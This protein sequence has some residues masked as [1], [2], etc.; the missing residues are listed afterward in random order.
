MRRFNG[1]KVSTFVLAGALG[2][3]G[4][5]GTAHAVP[6]PQMRDAL[7]RLGEARAHLQAA[8]KHHGGHRERALELTLAA[9]DEVNAGI[10]WAN[11]H[12]D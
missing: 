2:V 4:V 12:D 7:T 3:F 11:T 6:Q 5:I 10:V 1:W 9:I 8:S